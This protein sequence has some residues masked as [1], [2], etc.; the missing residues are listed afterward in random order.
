MRKYGVSPVQ[1]LPYTWEY[2]LVKAC[3]LEYFTCWESKYSKKKHQYDLN[4]FLVGVSSVNLL[5]LKKFSFFCREIYC[6]L[7]ISPIAVFFNYLR[8]YFCLS[9]NYLNFSSSLKTMLAIDN[10]VQT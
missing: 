8:I 4:I 9:V 7:L 1:I 10:I 3:I 2:G 5:S 6:S